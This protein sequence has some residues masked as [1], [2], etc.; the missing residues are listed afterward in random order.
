MA[1]SQPITLEQYNELVSYA[2]MYGRTW[3]QSL[4]DDWMAARSEP[5]LHA[6]RNTHGPAWLEK[7]SFS[8]LSSFSFQK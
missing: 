2:A 6:L 8:N 5:V 3:K 7:F 1:S 4:R